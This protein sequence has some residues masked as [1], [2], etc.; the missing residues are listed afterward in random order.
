[1][2]YN[3]Q[4]HSVFLDFVHR[5]VFSKLK[6]TTFWKL[7]KFPSSGEVGVEDAYSAGPLEKGSPLTLGR[8]QIQIFVIFNIKIWL[9]TKSVCS[10][11]IC[12]DMK[13]YT[14]KFNGSL[15]KT[16]YID[17]IWQLRCTKNYI[18]WIYSCFKHAS[19][20]KTSWSASQQ[21]WF[22]LLCIH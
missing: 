15:I 14:T 3:T 12:L 19:P 9:H 4:N 18:I 16:N 1:M 11:R 13:Y 2:V 10:F 17:L 7:D 21:L 20:Y 22:L 8:K 5:P 6:N